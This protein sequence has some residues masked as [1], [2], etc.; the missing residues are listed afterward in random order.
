MGKRLIAATVALLAMSVAGCGT[1]TPPKRQDVFSAHLTQ[2]TFKGVWP[3]IPSSGVL[4]CDSA[5][6]AGAVTF[7]PDGSGTTYAINGPALDW[8]KDLHWPDAKQ[9]WSGGNWGGFIDT[10]LKMCADKADGPSSSAAPSGSFSEAD[11]RG[12]YSPLEYWDKTFQPATP[13]DCTAQGAEV[14]PDGD[15]LASTNIAHA[16]RLAG[17]AL[18]CAA[19][20]GPRSAGRVDGV[21]L[22]FDPNVD[23]QAALNA[24]ASILP[25]DAKPDGSY[26]GTNAANSKYPN[27]GCQVEVYGSDTLAAA[28]TQ[29]DPQDANAADPHKVTV[30]LSSG[31]IQPGGFADQPFDPASVQF[32]T[33]LAGDDPPGSDG[34]VTC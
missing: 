15:P 7:T 24:I 22:Y 8:G 11:L 33:I 1:S 6:G 2:A 9:I 34:T 20:P 16:W 29:F 13:A 32:A 23:S 12:Y 30:Q 27:G 3:V 5:K 21:D 17:G 28:L 31:S 4:A 19:E 10:G 14:H 26:H 18:A 25:A